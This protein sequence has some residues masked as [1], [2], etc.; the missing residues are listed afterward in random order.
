MSTTAAPF[1]D[2]AAAVVIGG[3]I[4]GC[5]V[6]LHLARAGLRD[7]LLVEKAELTSGSTH[8]A[9]GL[10]TQFNPS[11]TMMRFRRYSV[12]LY[13][14]L[15]AFNA[16]GSVRVASSRDAWL[17]LRRDASRAEA[18]GFTAELLSPEE[19]VAR[20]P[21]ASAEGVR[22]GLWVGSDG[23]VDPHIVTHAVADAARAE[24]VEIRLRTRLTA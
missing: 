21:E 5:S 1:P 13:E 19:V 6:A 14:S 16:V 11:A 22:G 23:W 20:T 4:A 17:A 3:G 18:N 24:G 9:A 15:G 10:V 8:H 12:E 2:R 7:V